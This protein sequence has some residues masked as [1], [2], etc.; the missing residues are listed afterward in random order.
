MTAAPSSIK[1]VNAWLY[2]GVRG[3][4]HFPDCADTHGR[5]V[6]EAH[7]TRD[8][9]AVAVWKRGAHGTYLVVPFRECVT[10]TPRMAMVWLVIGP[11]AESR[12]DWSEA[13]HHAPAIA[14]ALQPLELRGAC[15]TCLADLPRA[16]RAITGW[17]LAHLDTHEIPTEVFELPEAE[18]SISGPIDQMELTRGTHTQSEMSRARIPLDL[19]S[20]AI[21]VAFFVAGWLAS[22]WWN[23][24]SSGVL[25]AVSEKVK[26][27]PGSDQTGNDAPASDLKKTTIAEP[28]SPSPPKVPPSTQ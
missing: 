21:M 4:S 13:F 5:L 7:R 12:D 3:G 17:T 2:W 23:H 15:V 14:R 1:R 11:L 25:T 24:D 16:S 20:V 9:C 6:L 18:V 22:Q 19:A 27:V 10:G 28:Q 26:G 8:D